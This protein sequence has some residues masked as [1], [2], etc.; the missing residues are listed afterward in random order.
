MRHG[1][2]FPCQARKLE[3][4]NLKMGGAGHFELDL[5]LVCITVSAVLVPSCIAWAIDNF[6]L[7]HPSP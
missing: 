5:H 7:T 1:V 6:T 2:F 3:E 4:A